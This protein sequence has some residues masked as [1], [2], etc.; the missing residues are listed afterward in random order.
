MSYIL[1]EYNKGGNKNRSKPRFA[2]VIEE[3]D[4]NVY[5]SNL[6]PVLKNKNK[7][8]NSPSGAR[9][10]SSG[11]NKNI[12]FSGNVTTRIKDKFGKI[13]TLSFTSSADLKVF[14]D[15][16]NKGFFS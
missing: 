14:L 13:I 3:Q 10:F 2:N 8:E 9:S 5:N 7:K 16:N 12:K 4:T 15:L 1:N 6:T 11:I